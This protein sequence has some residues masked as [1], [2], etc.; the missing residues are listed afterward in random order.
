M[1]DPPLAVARLVETDQAPLPPNGE[2]FWVT[3][4]DGLQLRTA[5]FRPEGAPR[6]SVILSPGR[7][8]PIEKY[9]EVIGELQARK[10]VVLVHDWRGQGLSGRSLPDR[11]MGHARGWRP[12]LADFDL[13]LSTFAQHLPKPWIAVGHSMGG[14]LTALALA[15]G[16][17]RFEAAVLSSPMLAINTGAQ[18]LGAVQRMSFLMNFA[19]RSKHQVAAAPDPDLDTFENNIL[20]HDK[21]RWERSRALVLAEPELALGGVTWGWLS[22]AL[23]LSRRIAASRAI[24]RLDI[25]V[26]IIAAEAEKLVVNDAAKALASRAP[27]GRYLEVPGAFHEILME[28]DPRR[29]IFWETFDGVAQTVNPEPVAKIKP[30]AKARSA[31]RKT[32]G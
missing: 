25:P 5:L 16:E 2:P 20:T 17:T 27:K 12:F 7:T 22:F 23:T 31:K 32:A 24:D 8:E 21:A 1:A 28:T 14:G 18:R 30:L 9:V 11:T 6:G 4:A 3:A 13:I 29:A 26:T 15:E 19:G 10:F